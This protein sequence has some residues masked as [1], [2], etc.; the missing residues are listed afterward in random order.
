MSEGMMGVR[1]FPRRRVRR[2]LVSAQ[3]GPLVV[4]GALRRHRRRGH[5]VER[6]HVAELVSRQRPHLGL[7]AVSER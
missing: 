7:D 6:E 1:S 2:R 3:P 5:G 4:L